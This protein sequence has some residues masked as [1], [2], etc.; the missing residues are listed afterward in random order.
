MKTIPQTEFEFPVAATKALII[1]EYKDILKANRDTYVLD[2]GYHI[3]IFE[4]FPPIK[5]IEEN[6][7]N[8]TPKIVRSY[9]DKGKNE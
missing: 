1:K 9:Y 2:L 4:Y 7:V 3:N 6:Y 8:A 5:Y